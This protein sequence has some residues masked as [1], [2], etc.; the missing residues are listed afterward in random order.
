MALNQ[1]PRQVLSGAGKTGQHKAAAVWDASTTL[2]G[3]Q[4]AGAAPQVLTLWLLTS[5]DSWVTV[6][7][8]HVGAQ[9]RWAPLRSAAVPHLQLRHTLN[10]AQAQLV[11]L[12][13]TLPPKPS[14][15]QQVLDLLLL[16]VVFHLLLCWLSDSPTLHRPLQLSHAS[17]GDDVVTTKKATE[18]RA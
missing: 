16:L 15:V 3:R 12:R 8:W 13:L 17:A 18:H 4:P 14:D 6:Y 1:F 9:F 7:H 2:L 11:E 10:L 5:F